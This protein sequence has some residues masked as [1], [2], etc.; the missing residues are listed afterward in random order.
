M[1]GW[2][3]TTGMK[4]EATDQ[5]GNM[6]IGQCEDVSTEGLQAAVRSLV[7]E[8]LARHEGDVVL[9]LDV[10]FGD[11]NGPHPD[12]VSHVVQAPLLPAR[13]A[14]EGVDALMAEIRA[15][16]PESPD[17]RIDVQLA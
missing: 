10:D 2:G 11:I 8:L 1:T 7:D 17:R 16:L 3:K 4:W 12:R 5:F 15:C 9:T 6:Y 13:V 14:A